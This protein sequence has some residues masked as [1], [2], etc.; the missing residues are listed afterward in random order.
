M[1]LTCKL[2]LL[3]WGVPFLTSSVSV[4]TFSLMHRMC[5]RV[6]VDVIYERFSIMLLF[7][8]RRSDSRRRGGL[9]SH[10]F[11]CLLV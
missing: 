9:L 5:T 4:S 2:L 3:A 8:F 11:A 10:L 7:K 1:Y 6:V